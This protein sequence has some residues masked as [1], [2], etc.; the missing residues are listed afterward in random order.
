MTL[1]KSK[2]SF[3]QSL[4]QKKCRDESGLFLVEGNKIITEVLDS[5]F[6]VQLLIAT[7]SWVESNKKSLHKV[8][9][10]ISV[11]ESD[12]ERVSLQKTPVGVVAVVK[13]KD[14]SII[15]GDYLGELSL[16]LDEIQ[17]P[18]NMGTIIRLADW[19]G[20]RHIF[21]STNTVDIYN[22]KVI[23]STMGAFLRCK[24]EYVDLSKFLKKHSELEGFNIYG[25][26]LEGENIYRSKLENK[27]FLV[28]GNEGSGISKEVQQ[29]VTS[30]ISIPSYPPSIASS[31]SLNV[32]VATAVICSEFRRRMV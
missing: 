6:E 32:A 18:G 13:K 29:H 24:V 30:K 8:Q 25:A 4:K 31:E 22:P 7:H 20:I 17:D 27:G 12:I 14:N 11:S 1:S 19:F 5:N 26:F 2:I 28:M 10:I 16:V 23:Q 15:E 21:C 3:V 9:E